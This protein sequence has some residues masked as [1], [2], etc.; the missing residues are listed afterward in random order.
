MP[1][2]LGREAEKRDKP[3]RPEPLSQCQLGGNKYRYYTS[4]GEENRAV[5]AYLKRKRDSEPPLIFADQT[6]PKN[7]GSK[8]LADDEAHIGPTREINTQDH[9]QHLTGICRRRGRKDT[10][11]QTAEQLADEQGGRVVGEED[12]ED[13]A[14]EHA[15]RADDGV[16]LPEAGDEV[17]VQQ[18]AE[19]GADAGTVAEASLPGGREL[20][21]RLCGLGHADPAAVLLLEGRVGPEVSDEDG[22]I[23]LHNDGHAAWGHTVSL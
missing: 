2:R 4:K 13:E 6:S 7:T 21:A 22:V 16:A 20:V 14:A 5:A 1:G 19:E 12:D 10:P 17:A 11:G 9:G 3:G 15:E 8:E 18:G 23:S